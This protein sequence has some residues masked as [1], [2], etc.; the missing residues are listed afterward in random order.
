MRPSLASEFALVVGVNYALIA[1]GTHV[2]EGMLKKY[3]DPK[4]VGPAPADES[5]TYEMHV[6]PLVRSCTKLDE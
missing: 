3:K 6:E 2:A 5:I 4:S 1:G